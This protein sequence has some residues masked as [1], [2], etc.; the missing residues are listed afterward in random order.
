MKRFL[1]WSKTLGI[2]GSLITGTILMGSWQALALTTEQVLERLQPVPLFTIGNSNNRPL[3][4]EAEDGAPVMTVF[5]SP[6]DAQTL[7]NQLK[8][9]NPQQTAEFRVIPVSLGGI[10]QIARQNEGQEQPLRFSFVPAQEQIAAART[11]LQENGE[12]PSQIRDVPLFV[13]AW[14]QGEERGY[15]MS[16]RG[17]ETVVPM[18]FDK[19]ELQAML[20]NLRQSQPELAS[21][22]SIE[23]VFLTEL[24]QTLETSDNEELN[25]IELVV[26]QESIR[27]IQSSQGQQGGQP[28]APNQPT[29]ATPNPQPAQPQQ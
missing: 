16:Q 15:L 21:N 18:F 22:V 17:D 19:A 10:Y 27:F 5:I 7:L 8:S 4:G 2:V 26:P 20:D 12:D 25:R 23:V 6:D 14:T 1:R 3:I 13:A 11:V 28:P 24:I 29:P 9:D